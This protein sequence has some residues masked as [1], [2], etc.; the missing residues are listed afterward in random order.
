MMGARSLGWSVRVAIGLFAVQIVWGALFLRG[1]PPVSGPSLML[2]VLASNL[3]VALVLVRLAERS[4]ARGLSLLTLLLA[5]AFGIPALYL[6]ETVFFDIGIPKGRL[7]ALYLQ[8]LVAGTAGAVLSAAAPGKLGG[9]L[10]GEPRPLRP[11]PLRPR[12]LALSTLSYVFVYSAAGLLAWPFLKAYYETR[13]MPPLG[14]VL[15]LQVVRGAALSLLVW[16]IAR[17]EPGGR[18]PAAVSS[19]LCLS[20][21]GGIAPLMIPGN[22]YL[23]DA[24]RQAHLVE[25]GISNFLFGVVAARLLA[26]GT[27][28]V[29]S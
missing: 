21:I 9:T 10:G 11:V 8:A 15:A 20:I 24:V 16:L 12:R 4:P 2:Y 23:P 25:V 14:T 22:P 1:E 5:V 19:G 28:G 3:F 18:R 7:G 17:H 27:D 13:P 26:D 6:L 29:R